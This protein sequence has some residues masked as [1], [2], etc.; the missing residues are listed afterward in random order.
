MMKTKVEVPNVNV[1]Y[2]NRMSIQEACENIMNGNSMQTD[3]QLI[4]ENQPDS[5]KNEYPI[6][7][8]YEIMP[9][10]FVMALKYEDE[11]LQQKIYNSYDSVIKNNTAAIT[12]HNKMKDACKTW[13]AQM[14]TEYNI[15]KPKL[16]ANEL[17]ANLAVVADGGKTE[18]IYNDLKSRQDELINTKIQLLKKIANGR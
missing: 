7:I 2:V 9:T 16:I 10:P 6:Q 11:P 17:K 14:L 18:K 1:K 13:A 5:A 4:S 15:L 8:N 3:Y 12:I